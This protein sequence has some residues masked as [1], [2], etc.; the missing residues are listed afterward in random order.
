MLAAF[1]TRHSLSPEF[2]AAA[3]W[4]KSELEA[5]GFTVAK[6]SISVGSGTSFNVIAD[7]TGTGTSRRL[8]IATAHLDSVNTAGGVMAD[9]PGADDNGQ[10]HCNG[11]SPTNQDSMST[12]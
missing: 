7:R 1:R 10:I 9:A 12:S 4:M 3:D 8:V 2:A 11:Q 5:V 6:R